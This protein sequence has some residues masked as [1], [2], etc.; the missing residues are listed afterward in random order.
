MNEDE[1]SFDKID[2]QLNGYWYVV[3]GRIFF[4]YNIENG[5][6]YLNDCTSVEIAEIEKLEQ[7][8]TEVE[9]TKE[10]IEKVS[11]EIRYHFDDYME[12]TVE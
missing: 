3:S 12:I 2:V 7:D 5:S 9:Y 1:Y 10:D 11:D 6:A 8:G 4:K